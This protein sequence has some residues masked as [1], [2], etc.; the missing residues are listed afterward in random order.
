MRGYPCPVQLDWLRRT[1]SCHAGASETNLSPDE[2][3]AAIVLLL[4]EY[5]RL[6]ARF[7]AH[8]QVSKGGAAPLRGH[9]E[10]RAGDGQKRTPTLA[11]GTPAEQFR[12]G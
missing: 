7:D 5:E 9:R 3:A 8:N 10:Q 11:G 1:V 12:S 4:E 6:M 2:H